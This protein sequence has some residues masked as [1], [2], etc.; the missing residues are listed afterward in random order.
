MRPDEE[1]GV[2]LKEALDQ[3]VR[4]WSDRPVQE[5]IRI[6]QRLAYFL[7]SQRTDLQAAQRYWSERSSS[8]ERLL[9]EVADWLEETAR[10]EFSGLQPPSGAGSVA[11]TLRAYL[12][13]LPKQHE[14]GR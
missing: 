10:K 5:W 8:G 1:M 14:P 12:A 11:K 7:R 2:L 13:T 6:A 4:T 3:D 9:R